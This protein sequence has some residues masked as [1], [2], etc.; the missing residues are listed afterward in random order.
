[1]GFFPDLEQQSVEDLKKSFAGV[2]ASDIPEEDRQ[3]YMEEL[4]SKMAESGEAGLSFLLQQISA[5]D[6]EK[7]RA[8]LVGLT[9][10]RE[11][12]L[13]KDRQQVKEVL[14]SFVGDAR[15]LVASEA[16]DGLR[17]LGFKET[18]KDVLPLLDHPSPYVVAS[19][20][21]FLSWHDPKNAKSLLLKALESPDPI[22]R[23]NAIDELEEMNCTEALP[24]LRR[25]LTDPDPDVRQAA[26][27]AVSNLQESE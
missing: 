23:Q 5:A 27:T 18:V 4:A 3:I 20:L 16:V 26:M 22:I 15:P 10:A 13:S 14:L 11:P 9:F 24:A 2:L 25:L 8:I 17:L 12:A 1:M 21:R 6:E 19:V 7:L